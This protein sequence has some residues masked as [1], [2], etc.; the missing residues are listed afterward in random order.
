[1]TETQ[2]S[3][4]YDTI[5]AFFSTPA[6]SRFAILRLKDGMDTSL[7][8]VNAVAVSNLYR[9]GDLLDDEKFTSMARASINAFEAEMLQHPWLFPGLLTGVVTARLGLQNKATAELKY[10]A[11]RE[12][13]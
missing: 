2:T 9:L 5:G 7:P 13:A 10:K 4:F 11:S 1:M 12:K 6:E 3:L 8:S